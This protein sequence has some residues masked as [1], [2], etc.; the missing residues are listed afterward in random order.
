M[1]EGGGAYLCLQCLEADVVRHGRGRLVHSG[2]RP[3]YWDHGMPAQLLGEPFMSRHVGRDVPRCI[4]Q[5]TGHSVLI[6]CLVKLDREHR[7]SR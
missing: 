4:F 2:R 3:R 5:V 6:E 1:V 7:L